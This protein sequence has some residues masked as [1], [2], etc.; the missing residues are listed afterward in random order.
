LTKTR[1]QGDA[2]VKIERIGGEGEARAHQRRQIR[3]GE[4]AGAAE[5][6]REISSPLFRFER[7]AKGREKRKSWPI[8]RRDGV[9][10]K[11]GFHGGEKIRRLGRE[12]VRGRSSWREV[13]DDLWARAVSGWRG[14]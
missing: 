3:S 1:G 11:L 13:E 4:L 6:R 9:G 10:R 5:I 12:A 7:R 2:P 8:Y 14:V